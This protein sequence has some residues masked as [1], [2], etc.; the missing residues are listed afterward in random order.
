V[1]RALYW[2][3]WPGAKRINPEHDPPGG[4]ITLAQWLRRR[5][6]PLAPRPVILKVSLPVDARPELT[7][8]NDRSLACPAGTLP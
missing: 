8:V 6:N 5:V 1:S 3:A 2:A 7:R 4:K